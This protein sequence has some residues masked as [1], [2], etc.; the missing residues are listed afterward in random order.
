MTIDLGSELSSI[1]RSVHDDGASERMSAQVNHMVGRIRRRRA[2]RHTATGAVGVGAAAAVTLGG[3]QLAGRDGVTAPAISPTAT[4]MPTVT[5]FGECGTTITDPNIGAD[6]VLGLDGIVTDV[7]EADGTQPL[8]IVDVSFTGET[9]SLAS[10]GEVRMVVARDGV[11]V[12]P[13]GE[14]VLTRESFPPSY[15]FQQPLV[16]CEDG[17]AL[18]DGEY[19]IYALQELGTQD[20]GPTSILGGPW[21]VTVPTSE[22]VE[23]TPSADDTASSTDPQA[24]L[25]ALLANPVPNP[26]LLFPICGTVAADALD[27]GMPPLELD[28]TESELTLPSGAAYSSTVQL[29]TTLG[30]HVIGN[31]SPN[32]TLV[33]LRDG[34][35]VGYQ[36]LDAGDATFVDLADGQTMD[37][38]VLGTMSLCGTGEGGSGPLVPLP[39]GDYRFQASMDVMVKEIGEPDGSAES[40]TFTMPAVSEVGY[41]TVTPP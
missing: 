20:P 6:P 41:L 19:E 1:A 17:A 37:F 3:F 28:L 25:D 18:P 38:T 24:A 10:I 27:D 40:V 31:A 7:D 30:R 13:L 8:A 4:S 14:L 2:V 23:P 21:S 11:V 12:G 26:D 32:A 36:F 39:A 29:K 9:G 33:V 15:T 34:I 16:S 22:P 35:V 5:G